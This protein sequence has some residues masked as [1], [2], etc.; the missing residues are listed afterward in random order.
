[1]TLESE[2]GPVM[3]NPSPQQIRKE[4]DALDGTGSGFL[5]LARDKLTYMQVAR[6]KAGFIVEYQEGSTD[7]H[8]RAFRELDTNDVAGLLLHYHEG[9]SSWKSLTDWEKVRVTKPWWKRWI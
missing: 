9:N 3:E 6:V 2:R 4:I 8:F 7:E 1:M 5:I